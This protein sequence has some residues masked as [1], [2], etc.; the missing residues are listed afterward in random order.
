MTVSY[1]AQLQNNPGWFAIN[2]LVPVLLPF[3]VITAVATATGG[4]RTFVL[5]LKKSVDSGQLFWVVIGML[6]ASGYEAFSAY[7]RHP[8]LGEFIAWTLGWC[9]VGA[10][11]SS[12]FIAINA[13][14]SLQQE[15]VRPIIVWISIFMTL[16]LSCYYPFVHFIVL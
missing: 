9:V 14:R 12:I 2:V 4:W 16:T 1:F 3:A 13:S 5:M 6:A 11:F 15:P 10:V 7:N 8:E